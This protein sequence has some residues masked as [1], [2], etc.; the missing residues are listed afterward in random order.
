MKISATSDKNDW[1]LRED[2][3]VLFVAMKA[4]MTLSAFPIQRKEEMT[5]RQC[6]QKNH[7]SVRFLKYVI[8]FTWHHYRVEVP[9]NMTDNKSAP[10]NTT[11]DKNVIDQKV[12]CVIASR[13]EGEREIIFLHAWQRE[14]E[15]RMYSNARPFFS[16]FVQHHYQRQARWRTTTIEHQEWSGPGNVQWKREWPDHQSN[17]SATR[18]ANILY[19]ILN[20]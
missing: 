19:C 11:K 2:V 13:S 15:K 7:T 8:S 17:E 1:M 9:S 5:M 3:E 6:E 10:W 12:R 14:W 16:H 18:L 4:S 20:G